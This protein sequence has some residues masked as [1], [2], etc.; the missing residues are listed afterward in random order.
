LIDLV[1]YLRSIGTH[2]CDEFGFG[3]FLTFG[4]T[5]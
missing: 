5:I 3:M 1:L 4:M 2:I